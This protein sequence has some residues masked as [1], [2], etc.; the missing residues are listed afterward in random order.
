MEDN[1]EFV[2]HQLQLPCLLLVT[3]VAITPKGCS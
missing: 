1:S 3:G 2:S